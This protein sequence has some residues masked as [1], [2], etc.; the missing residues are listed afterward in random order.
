[1]RRFLTFIL[2]VS[3]F[4]LQYRL[5]LGAGSYSEI[6]KLE[7]KIA[8]YQQVFTHDKKRNMSL[9]KDIE[10]LKKGNAAL[11]ELA[12]EQLGLIK[13]DEYFFRVIHASK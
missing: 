4:W 13:P 7:L 6:N 8:Q 9:R 3:L 1:M 10:S 5:W 2:I 11:E 12:R